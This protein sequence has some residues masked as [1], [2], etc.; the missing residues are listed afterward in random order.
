MALPW[1]D[2]TVEHK[3]LKPMVLDDGQ[4]FIRNNNGTIG[5]GEEIYSGSVA[6]HDTLAGKVMNK[7]MAEVE[8]VELMSLNKEKRAKRLAAKVT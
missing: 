3:M 5:T 7:N 6:S 2:P 8:E 1:E 4:N